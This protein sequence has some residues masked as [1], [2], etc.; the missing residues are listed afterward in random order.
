MGIAIPPEVG[1]WASGMAA[2]KVKNGRMAR[3]KECEKYVSDC[4][5]V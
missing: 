3:I 5:T 2:V 4:D 1:G